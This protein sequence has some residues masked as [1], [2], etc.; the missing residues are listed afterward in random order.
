MT[1]LEWFI[2][3]VALMALSFCAGYAFGDALA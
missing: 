1:G 2:L 3:I